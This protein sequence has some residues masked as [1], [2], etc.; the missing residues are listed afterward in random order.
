[1]PCVGDHAWVTKH[2]YIFVFCL[3][4]KT[5]EYFSRVGDGR[6]EDIFLKDERVLYSKTRGHLSRIAWNTFLE[7][8]MEGVHTELPYFHPPESSGKLSM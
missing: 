4:G 7:L 1:M 3:S 8:A 5:R 2:Q 6:Q